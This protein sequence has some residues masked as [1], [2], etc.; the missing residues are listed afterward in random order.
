MRDW[1]GHILPGCANGYARRLRLRDNAA[2]EVARIGGPIGCGWVLE[3]NAGTEPQD[4][5]VIYA[6]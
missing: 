2:L 3:S 5:L 1:C 4:H 6:L